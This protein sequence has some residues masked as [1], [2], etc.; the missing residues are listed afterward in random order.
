[1]RLFVSLSLTTS[2]PA[3]NSVSRT[4]LMKNLGSNEKKRTE[5][6]SKTTRQLGALE[7]LLQRML[8]D[9]YVWNHKRLIFK[10][11]VQFMTFVRFTSMTT[12]SPNSLVCGSLQRVR[13][14]SIPTSEPLSINNW[15]TS[16]LRCNVWISSKQH[17]ALTLIAMTLIL[18][19]LE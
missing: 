10:N 15:F 14:H 7:N 12:P 16:R 17:S 19:E 3:E 6:S 18:A 9:K 13:C 11:P 1:M 2:R 5:C 8:I 4:K